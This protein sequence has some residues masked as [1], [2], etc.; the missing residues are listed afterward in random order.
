[1]ENVD[2]GGGEVGPV[3]STKQAGEEAAGVREEASA[4]SEVGGEADMG[5]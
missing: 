4:G 2:E 3:A 1:M 5:G